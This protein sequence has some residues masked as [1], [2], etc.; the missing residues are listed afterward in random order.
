MNRRFTLVAAA[1]G[2]AIAFLLGLVAAESMVSRPGIAAATGWAARTG[3][4]QARRAATPRQATSSPGSLSPGTLV[5]FADVA[6]RLNPA[7]VNIEAGT[8][9]RPTG[10]GTRR[11]PPGHPSIPGLDPDPH[12]GVDD[13]RLDPHGLPRDGAGSGFI[14]EPDGHIL[15]NH[16]VVDRADRIVVKLSD[17]RTF[18]ARVVGAD[19]A[20][21]IALIKVDAGAPLPVAPLGDSTS[22]R[23]GEWVC[24]IGNPLAFEH[25]V[26]VGVVSYLGR[27][28]FDASL[29]D[30][31]Q[32]DAAI[33]FG[34]SGGPLI[35]ARGEVIGIN[36]A[37]SWRASNIGFA[38][39][40]NQAS[41]I[42]A[43]L[44]ARGRVARG[45]MG[46]TLKDLEPGL[47]RSLKLGTSVGAL[48]QDVAEQSPG[49]R[50]GLRPYDVIVSVDGAPVTSND[51]LIR[52]IAGRAPGVVARVEFFRDGRAR[53]V[54]VR[55]AERPGAHAEES[56]RPASV[57]PGTARP[58][59]EPARPTPAA[60][61]GLQVKELEG[62]LARRAAV[63]P[64]LRGVLV[65]SVEPLGLAEEAGIER[66]DIVLE[67]NRQP[68]RTVDDYL[69]VVGEVQE[70]ELLA[71]Y[72]YVPSLGQRVLR[73]VRVEP[74]HE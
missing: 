58:G 63:P 72:C 55:L 12:E 73:T 50:A 69:R 65:W 28:L 42:L 35:N 38:I 44:K 41:A 2:S 57:V 9:A 51:A 4:P 31:I 1:L 33:N 27:K 6:A 52:Y 32:T 11:L 20:T 70:G 34:N 60:L 40:I 24:A 64:A 54:D 62:T 22:L 74:W 14:I 26:T 5:D 67:V 48:V 47:E 3:P 45:Y 8:R 13:P 21:D 43:Q 17:G 10:P 61:L 56:A 66:G 59:E 39:P 49:E 68:V 18:R 37:I 25:T 19:P 46:V 23:V 53:S 71:F 36:A 16:H 15:T 30:Y 7:V 29:D